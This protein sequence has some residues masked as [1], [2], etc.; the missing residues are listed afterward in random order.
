MNTHNVGHLGIDL[1]MNTKYVSDNPISQWLIRNFMG[2]L[3]S[4]VASIET[5]PQQILDVGCGEGIVPRQLRPLWP[6][7]TLHGLD[8]DPALLQVARQ[9]VAD[10]GCVAGSIYSLPVATAAYDLVFC[11]EVLE[12][13]QK[14]EL[15][16]AEVTRVGKGYFLFSVPNEPWWR[17]ANMA[18]GS[19]WRE[20]GNTPSHLNHWSTA[21]FVQL[22]SRYCNVVQVKR[23]F[24]WTMVLCQK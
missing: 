10:I 4:L 8:V 11:T 9:L 3:L 2:A 15:A 5:R 17:L 7:V 14:P 19:Y 6:S 21:E 1:P 18:R 13:L 20:W 16:V 12:H 24:P 22:L 23:P